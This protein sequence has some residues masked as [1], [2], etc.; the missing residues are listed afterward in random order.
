MRDWKKAMKTKTYH[1]TNLGSFAPTGLAD[2]EGYVRYHVSPR[3]GKA[4]DSQLADWA[5]SRSIAVRNAAITE[6]CERRLADWQ[7]NG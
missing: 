5:D 2:N 6:Q 3:Y 4:T 7:K 1:V